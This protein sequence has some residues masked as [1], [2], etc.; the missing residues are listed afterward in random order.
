MAIA[1]FLGMPQSTAHRWAKEAMPVR[2][3]GRNVVANPEEL[4][5]WLQRSS[6]EPVGSHVV[7]PDTDLMKD[8]RASLEAKKQ[9]RTGPSRSKKASR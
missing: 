3:L 5:R 7:T 9:R 4:N 8:L 6:G 2:R 1:Q